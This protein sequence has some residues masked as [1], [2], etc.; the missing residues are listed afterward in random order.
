MKTISLL[1]LLAFL[2]LPNLHADETLDK[3]GKLTREQRA[4]LQQ[5]LE[6]K[7]AAE[8]ENLAITKDL[9]FVREQ[10][11]AIQKNFAEKQRELDGYKA[12]DAW[13]QTEYPKRQAEAGAW[14]E[15]YSHLSGKVHTAAMTVGAIVAVIVG[16]AVFLGLGW[17]ITFMGWV[18]PA[19]VAGS[20]L[21]AGGAVAAA[22]EI[23][24]RL[25]A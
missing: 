18:G 23:F 19:I 3:I 16:I 12:R 2:S 9:E 4:V 7:N 13:Y 6:S 25:N 15:K 17:N 1:L 24:F 22:I 14:R 8:L 20:G 5:A 10:A 11:E 21:I